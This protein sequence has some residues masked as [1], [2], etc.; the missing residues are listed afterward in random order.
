MDVNNLWT[1]GLPTWLRHTASN[2][3][4]NIYMGSAKRMYPNFKYRN[5]GSVVWRFRRF[6]YSHTGWQQYKQEC[7][8]VLSHLLATNSF[9]CQCKY[10]PLLS[11]IRIKIIHHQIRCN[12]RLQWRIEDLHWVFIKMKSYHEG[13]GEVPLE[14]TQIKWGNRNHLPAASAHER[15]NHTH[16]KPQIQDLDRKKVYG[17]SRK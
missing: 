2:T 17:C 6:P 12:F 5:P 10:Q 11:A 4:L 8:L 3:A 9:Y 7:K 13:L 14:C 15:E 16:K 1:N